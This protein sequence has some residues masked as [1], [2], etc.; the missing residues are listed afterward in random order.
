MSVQESREVAIDA[1]HDS[2]ANTDNNGNVLTHNTGI[3]S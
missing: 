3:S 2:I 1:T